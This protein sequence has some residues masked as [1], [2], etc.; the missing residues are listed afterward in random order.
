MK[1]QFLA[2]EKAR[3]IYR[4]T[5]TPSKVETQ[6]LKTE[7]GNF[8]YRHFL[9]GNSPAGARVFNPATGED[10]L[11]EHPDTFNYL[12]SRCKVVVLDGCLTGRQVQRNFAKK[13]TT[14]PTLGSF[15]ST[16]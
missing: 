14:L 16:L 6:V 13:R 5:G 12:K 2:C 7:N 11:T 10:S 3:A 15:N 4:M 8:V 9:S 1:N